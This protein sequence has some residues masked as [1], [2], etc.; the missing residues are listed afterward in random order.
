M[1]GA[2]SPSTFHP[3]H[4]D[5]IPSI[6]PPNQPTRSS[7]TT[8]TPLPARETLTITPSACVTTPSPTG[9]SPSDEAFYTPTPPRDVLRI[10][11][12]CPNTTISSPNAGAPVDF[13][14]VEHKDA[15][16]NDIVWFTAYTLQACIDGCTAFNRGGQTDVKCRGV[17]L[18]EDL[19]HQAVVNAGANCW[20]KTKMNQSA[21]TD[22]QTNTVA[23]LV[24]DP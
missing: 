24:D 1:P 6:P 8:T 18:G 11:V 5:I 12:S 13:R 23:W 9:T 16:L 15:S 4:P 3:N 17:A 14:C 2:S 19:S 22:S 7:P 21:F 10:D 20:L